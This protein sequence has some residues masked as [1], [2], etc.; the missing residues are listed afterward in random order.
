MNVSR[1]T[2]L[3][4]SATLLIAS[5]GPGANPAT[6][7][8]QP[9]PSLA[10]PP[11]P[12]S[13]LSS[14]LSEIGP[15]GAVPRQTALEAFTLGFGPLPGVS[16]VPGPPGERADG[17]IAVNWV[18]RYWEQLT[19]AQKTAIKKYLPEAPVTNLAGTA[20]RGIALGTF[21]AGPITPPSGP[22]LSMLEHDRSEI[23]A[24]V[25][26]SM[27]LPLSVV[28]SSTQT[29]TYL[30]YTT[31]YDSSGGFTG[32]PARCQ[33]TIEPR[34]LHFPDASAVADSLMHEMF[35][36]FQATDYATVAAYV[37]APD[38]L[39][40]GSAAW[41]GEELAP[42]PS[43]SD[44]WWQ[45]YL[46]DIGKS[47]FARSYD[48]IG[49]FAHMEETGADPWHSFDPMFKAH[50]SA[51]A[52]ALATDHQFKLTWASSLLRK[53]DFGDGWDTTGPTI[54]NVGFVPTVHVLA[55]G[56]ALSGKVSPYTNAI[57]GV[58]TNANALE[59]SVNT[60][61]SRLHDSTNHDFNDLD[62][63]SNRFCLNNCS[64][65]TELEA[66]P[67][68]TGG[69]V[70]LAIT[71]DSA[72]A[73]YSI[74]AFNDVP[75]LAGDWVTTDWTLLSS[76]G[77]VSGGA[78]VRY[79]ITSSTADIDFTGM[80]PLGELRFAGRGVEALT[81]PQSPTATSGTLSVQ[82]LPSSD[83]TLSVDGGAPIPASYAKSPVHSATG[84]WSCSAKTMTWHLANSTGSTVLDF[85][86]QPT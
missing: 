75:C 71:G 70:W 80:A 28:V 58:N 27:A 37:K 15:D 38:W 24:H 64:A 17:T 19:V 81:Y 68:L 77:S 55:A 26:H 69:E 20:G 63:S 56:Q 78:G 50:T 23:A 49:F 34:L 12:G 2:L 52:Y 39:I 25:G 54:P 42:S 45:E 11:A 48:A 44:G 1:F 84:T 82:E 43:T 51:A 61:Y 72:G 8:P 60:P 83:I 9:R 4:L 16:A 59:V 32:P 57:V 36:C 74:N 29:K 22:Y 76:A 85:S 6:A 86:R 53:T 79:T 3:G 47:L 67:R 62:T 31:V 10:G 66:L 30:A 46:L 33:V 35:H 18:L 65:D 41:V 14:V 73:T 7:A 5:G 21:V 40:E 13:G